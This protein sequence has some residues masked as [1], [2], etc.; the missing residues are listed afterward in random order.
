MIEVTNVTKR[1]GDKVAVDDLTF[2]VQPGIVT[3]FLGPNGAGKST[4]MRL[5]LGLDAPNKGHAP[6]NGKPYR[7]HRSPLHEVGALLEAR[8][9]HTGRSAYNHLLALA[10]THGIG[11]APRQR[12]DRDGRAERGRAQ[13][14]RRLLARHGSAARDRVGAARRPRY[15]DA[16]RAGQRPRPRGHPVGAQPAAGARRRGADGVR[17]LAPDERDG[18]DRRAPD[19]DR[20][21]RADRRHRRRRLRAARLEEGGAG[22]LAACQRARGAALSRPTSPSTAVEPASSRSP[23]SAP[24]R[25]ARWPPST[26]SSCYELSPQ[27]ASLEEAFM[28]LTHD[29]VEFH[30][31]AP[32]RARQRSRG[33][34]A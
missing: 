6:V 3:G 13:A 2:T 21:R 25:S 5:I 20:P 16:R 31:E 28:E 32:D 22:P 19:R 10:Q 27:T 30:A 23:A 34:S 17:L 26:G 4:T 12:A 11:R 1:Y 7:D 9:V 24:S 8:S 33:M 14:R 18:D 15:R 29:S